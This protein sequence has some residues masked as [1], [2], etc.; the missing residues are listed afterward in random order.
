LVPRFHNASSVPYF[1]N[2]TTKANNLYY[3]YLLNP[4]KEKGHS[5]SFNARICGD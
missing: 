1:Q 4:K 2:G 5:G 3:F